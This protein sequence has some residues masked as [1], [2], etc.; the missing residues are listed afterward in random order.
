VTYDRYGHLFPGW[1]EKL[2][3]KLDA[4]YLESHVDQVTLVG[5]GS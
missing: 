1:D 4:V 3:S 2:S 5:V